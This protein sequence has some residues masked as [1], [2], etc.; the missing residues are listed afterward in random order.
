MPP[1]RSWFPQGNGPRSHPTT[2]HNASASTQH[3]SHSTQISQS[4]TFP[5]TVQP[6]ASNDPSDSDDDLILQTTK[7]PTTCP[8]TLLPFQ[9]PVTSTLCPHSFEKSAILEMLRS[10]SACRLATVTDGSSDIAVMH[11]IPENNRR[12]GGAP[13]PPGYV[14]VA[15]CPVSGCTKTLS[16]AEIKEDNVLARRMKREKERKEREEMERGLDESSAGGRNNRDNTSNR[17]GQ[18]IELGDES[19]LDADMDVDMDV[20][21]EEDQPQAQEKGKAKGNDKG[22]G[23]GSRR[24]GASSSRPIATMTI[25]EDSSEEEE[26]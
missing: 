3:P 16:E 23:K 2:K 21:D 7:H 24:G 20:K 4:S 14:R 8:L 9:H 25:G 17:E 12:G 11:Y 6:P 22:K 15:K 5:P 19:F 13:V 18:A 26:E 10:S 1:V